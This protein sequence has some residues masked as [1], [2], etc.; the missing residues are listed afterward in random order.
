MNAPQGPGPILALE[1]LPGAFSVCRLEPDLPFP[2]WALAPGP[3]CSVTRTPEEWS[4]VCPS[5][6][7]PEGVRQEGGWRA[8]KVQGPLPFEAVGILAALSSTLAAAGV[9][10]FAVSTYDTDY[11]LVKE[12]RMETALGALR[13]AGHAIHLPRE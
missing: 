3:L 4:V 2:P 8:L 13:H 1:L 6:R 5:G 9:S 11:L 10:L 12:S 7:V